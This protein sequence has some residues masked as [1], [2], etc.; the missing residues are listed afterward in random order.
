MDTPLLKFGC[1]RVAQLVD[2]DVDVD[3]R[4]VAVPAVVCGVVGQAPAGSVDARAEQRAA[5][6]S[7]VGEVELEQGDVAA[8]VEQYG[9]ALPWVRMCSSSRRRSMSST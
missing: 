5:G 6:V 2:V 9:A 1:V 7:G 3:G 4:A 8:V